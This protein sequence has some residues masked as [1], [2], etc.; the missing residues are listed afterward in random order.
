MMLVE[1]A[2]TVED[3]LRLNSEKV[4]IKVQILQKAAQKIQ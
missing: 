4:V 2:E 1:R 3:L